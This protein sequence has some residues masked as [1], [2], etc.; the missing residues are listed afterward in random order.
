MKNGLD[1]AA[2]KAKQC[3]IREGYPE[4]MELRAHRAISWIGRAKACGEGQTEGQINHLDV[5]P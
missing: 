5:L 4:T 3:A 1:H 2:L